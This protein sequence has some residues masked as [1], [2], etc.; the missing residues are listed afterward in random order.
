MQ[1]CHCKATGSNSRRENEVIESEVLLVGKKIKFWIDENLDEGV[2]QELNWEW[3]QD[4]SNE[5]DN[6]QLDLWAIVSLWER[7]P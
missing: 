2:A 1:A 7:A 5:S 6:L 4:V 3:G